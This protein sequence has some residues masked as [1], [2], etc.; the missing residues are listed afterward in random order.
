MCL[1]GTP[2]ARRKLQVV[3]ISWKVHIRPVFMY[4]FFDLSIFCHLIHFFSLVQFIFNPHGFLLRLFGWAILQHNTPKSFS[5]PR[6]GSWPFFR[7]GWRFLLGFFFLIWPSV[8]TF[9]FSKIAPLPKI[10]APLERRSTWR[11][12]MSYRAVR[13]HGKQVATAGGRASAGASG[14]AREVAGPMAFRATGA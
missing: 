3:L 1:H 11:R 2:K 7:S 5:R 13:E 10:L 12:H 14:V 9:F 4:A 6:V 8:V